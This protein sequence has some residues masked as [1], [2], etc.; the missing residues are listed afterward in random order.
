MLWAIRMSWVSQKSKHVLGRRN[1]GFFPGADVGDHATPASV[2]AVD[3]IVEIISVRGP[4]RPDA[5]L[6]D[7]LRHPSFHA[8][9][10]LF[11]LVGEKRN[12]RSVR[13]NNRKSHF[14]RREGQLHAFGSIA[15]AAPQRVVRVRGIHDPFPVPEECRVC[16]RDPGEN[17][18]K[19][20]R[21]HVVA[22]QFAT[23][24][25]ADHKNLLSIA[26]RPWRRVRQR[27]IRES[28]RPPW[29]AKNPVCIGSTQMSDC[30]SFPD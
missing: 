4:T 24:L 17:R 11:T 14:H 18:K 25:R 7:P 27:T 29:A 2:L 12:L 6:V 16:R 8:D 5:F 9:D 26:A 15:A 19:L 30:W 22:N 28:N 23:L 20:M 1:S 10:K 13:R 3:L 21:L